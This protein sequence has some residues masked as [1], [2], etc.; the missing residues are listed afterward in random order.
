M[1]I[2]L[3]SAST[4]GAVGE[5]RER[6]RVG[7]ARGVG[8]RRCRSIA[9]RAGA[10]A[11]SISST[12]LSRIAPNT[13]VTPS[14]RD[15]RADATPARARRPGC[16]PRRAGRGSRRR[17]TSRAAPGQPAWPGPARIASRQRAGR[18]P[19]AVDARAAAA[20]RRRSR[21]DARRAATSRHA[22]RRGAASAASRVGPDQ[23]ARRARAHT[24]AITASA[25]AGSGPHT[26]GMPGLMMPAFSAAIDA[27]VSP[28]CAW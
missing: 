17:R 21:A 13:S 10:S 6:V 18:A 4:A 15:L 7:S 23:R 16:A 27:S 14:R 28:S 25:S 5:R 19:V 8:R 2:R 3:D 12:A 26:T 9:R 22:P 24:A 11:A 20:R 1:R